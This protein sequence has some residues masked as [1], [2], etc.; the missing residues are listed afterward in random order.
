MKGRASSWR[1]RSSTPF[2]VSDEQARVTIRLAINSLVPL[3]VQSS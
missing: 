2:R 3:A 1:T